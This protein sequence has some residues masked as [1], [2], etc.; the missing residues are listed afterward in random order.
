MYSKVIP[1]LLKEESV[2]TKEL[3]YAVRDL[4]EKI[5]VRSKIDMTEFCPTADIV[6]G[7][8]PLVT[9][10]NSSLVSMPPKYLKSVAKFWIR[11]TGKMLP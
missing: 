2:A 11:T 10:C 4:E 7:H 9:I 5:V 1:A 3:H 8:Y 6:G